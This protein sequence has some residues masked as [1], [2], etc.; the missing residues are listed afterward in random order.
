[1]ITKISETIERSG[2]LEEGRLLIC[3]AAKATALIVE[4][5]HDGCV[6]FIY[7]GHRAQNRTLPRSRFYLEVK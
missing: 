3:H 7:L 5:D 1:M 4:C 6:E 2:K